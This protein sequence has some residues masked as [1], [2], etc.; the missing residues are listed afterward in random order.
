[1]QKLST[2]WQKKFGEEIDEDLLYLISVERILH[3]EDFNEVK[4]II[5]YQLLLVSSYS[6]VCHLGVLIIVLQCLFLINCLL[7]HYTVNFNTSELLYF[8]KKNDLV[9]FTLQEKMS[10]NLKLLMF[11]ALHF[12]L[13]IIRIYIVVRDGLF[14]H[15]FCTVCRKQ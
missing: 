7:V 2:R 8:S 5:F 14:V 3:I 12:V 9:F 10:P 1:M 15:H 13:L 4:H 11:F 6:A